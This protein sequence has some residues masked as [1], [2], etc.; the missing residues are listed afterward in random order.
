MDGMA[1][2]YSWDFRYIN[3]G[4]GRLTVKSG[5]LLEAICGIFWVVRQIYGVG[6]YYLYRGEAVEWNWR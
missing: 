4:L 1:L 2:V 5:Q 6:G 3:L